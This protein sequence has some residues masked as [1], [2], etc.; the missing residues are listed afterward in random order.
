MYEKPLF[1]GV[2]T[3][4]VTPFLRG[5][6][7]YP[8]LE[9]LLQ[10]QMD[11]GIKAIV[12][13]GTTGES[14]T[15][16]D[17]EKLELFR[18]SKEF[19]GDQC[20]IVAG[21]GSNCTEH[22]VCLSQAAQA[23]GVDG[24]LLVSPYYNKATPDGLIAHYST[25]AAAVQLPCILYNVPSRTGVDIPV[26]VYRSL[27]RIP[28]IAGVKEASSD[29]VKVARILCECPGFPVWSGNDDQI[30]PVM[31][32]GGCGVISVLSNVAPEKTKA[33]ADAALDGDFD[34]AAALQL[35]L[36][37]LIRALFSEVNP[38]PVKAAMKEL[39]FDCGNCRLPL[40]PMSQENFRKLL[41]AL[42]L[43]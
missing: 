21:T 4:L 6:V 24:L 26:E 12:I 17:K 34:T 5:E 31:A 7:N 10:A 29:I 39:G 9:R 35:R 42:P 37:P 40:T 32:L 18:R 28:N 38:I 2:C 36:L 20:K 27:S 30:V 22:A 33:M 3:A 16:S 15:L 19:V 14:P 23:L 41:A 8:M 11:A 25:I 43:R 13:C 1:T